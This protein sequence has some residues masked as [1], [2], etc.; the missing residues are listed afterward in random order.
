MANQ[1]YEDGYIKSDIVLSVGM[2]VSNHIQY[3]EKCLE[4]LKPLLEAVPAELIILDT[5]GPEN[6]DGSIEVCRKYTDKIFRFTWCND[7]SAARNELLKYAQGEWF[8]YQDDDEWFE[9]VEELIDFFKSDKVHKYNCGFYHTKDYRI[10]GSSSM[11]IAGRMVRRRPD[12]HFVHKVHENFN[13]ANVPGY[14]FN[15]YTNHQGYV[16]ETEEQR[17]AKNKRNI[18]LLDEELVSEGLSPHTCAQK[19]QE[20]MSLPETEDEGYKL[21]EEYVNALIKMGYENDSCVQWLLCVQPRLLYIKCNGEALIKRVEEIRKTYKLLEY[22]KLCL[23]YLETEAAINYTNVSNHLEL[24]SADI[25]EFVSIYDYFEANP[26][27]KLAETQLDFPKYST[28]QALNSMLLSGGQVE[29]VL[30]DYRT[31]YSYWKKTDWSLVEDPLSHKEDILYT[32][33]HIE[34]VEPLE[35]YYKFFMNP[36][37]FEPG[38]E[39]YLPKDLRERKDGAGN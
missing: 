16:F 7:F 39:K 11:A 13:E 19:I 34:D 33:Q 26:E 17:R 25:K 9:N 21:C 31:A 2:L 10:D 22:A 24:I 20:M 18:M 35:S 30:T 36:E 27:K 29:N 8:M 23:D 14:M 28:G 12:T 1:T 3:I 32:L 5:V 37:L 38:F 15:S 4:G 6:S